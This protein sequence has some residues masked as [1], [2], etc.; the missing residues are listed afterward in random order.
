MKVGG[1]VYPT[2]EVLPSFVRLPAGTGVGEGY[3]AGV[4]LFGLSRASPHCTKN[5]WEPRVY[6]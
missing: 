2:E 5:E 6:L 3:V 1:A 4:G